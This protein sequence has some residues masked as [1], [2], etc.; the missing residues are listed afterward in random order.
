MKLSGGALFF[1]PHKLGV[2]GSIQAPAT[3]LAA[4]HGGSAMDGSSFVA[5]YDGWTVWQ[6]FSRSLFGVPLNRRRA[7]VLGGGV[8]INR[9]SKC[10]FNPVAVTAAARSFSSLLAVSPSLRRVA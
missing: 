2:V 7:L 3:T 9:E 4:T 5:G 10:K 1:L 6:Q 8:A